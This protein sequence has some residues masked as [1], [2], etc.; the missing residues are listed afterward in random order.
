MGEVVYVTGVSSGLGKSLVADEKLGSA[1]ERHSKD[2][3]GIQG[4]V[5]VYCGINKFVDCKDFVKDN[6]EFLHRI[7]MQEPKHIV[8][9][10]SVDVYQ[11]EKNSYAFF[12]IITREFF[13]SAYRSLHSLTVTNAI[14]QLL[15]S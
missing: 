4:S 12:E 14:D 5:V 1:L 3:R 15:S 6:F 10:S 2:L 11:K 13:K 7:V 8:F 9:I